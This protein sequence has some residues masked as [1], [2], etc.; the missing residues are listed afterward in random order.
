MWARLMELYV[1][2][3]ALKNYI[4]KI[5]HIALETVSQ[6]NPQTSLDLLSTG[7]QNSVC[8]LQIISEQ[9]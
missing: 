6:D 7:E 9:C 3:A 8:V 4:W 1:T 5:Q 2:L